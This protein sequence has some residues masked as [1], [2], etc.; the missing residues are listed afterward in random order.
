MFLRLGIRV[1]YVWGSAFLRL[2]AG[3]SY[4]W[5]LAFFCLGVKDC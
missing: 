5:E 3:N 1:S 4:I 2:M